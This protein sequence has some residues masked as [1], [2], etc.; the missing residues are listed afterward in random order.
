MHYAL[1]C[2]ILMRKKDENECFRCLIHVSNDSRNYMTFPVFSSL[3]MK[4]SHYTCTRR[5]QNVSVPRNTGT[6]FVICV[7]IT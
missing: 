3:S 5:V 7:I 4:G 2:L 6:A 1:I